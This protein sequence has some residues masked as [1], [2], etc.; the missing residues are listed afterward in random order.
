MD[1]GINQLKK[2][3]AQESGLEDPNAV[4]ED[5][6]YYT[7]DDSVSRRYLE[8]RLRG[9]EIRA[10]DLRSTNG[11][12]INGVKIKEA[13]VEAGAIIKVGD[14]ELRTATVQ[15]PVTIPLS[16]KTNFGGLLGKSTAMRQVFGILERVAPSE[17]TVEEGNPFSESSTITRAAVFFPIPGT[18]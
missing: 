2:E 9:D 16:S 8:L 18:L 6:D 4:E 5:E 13:I 11:T 14:T 10:V 7:D 17:A 15:E 12:T 3:M 1:E